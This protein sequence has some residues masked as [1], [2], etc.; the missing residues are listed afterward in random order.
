MKFKARRVPSEVD[1][2]AHDVE[3]GMTFRL[4]RETAEFEIRRYTELP[5]RM[6]TK[7]VHTVVK[8]DKPEEAPI[9]FDAPGSTEA[10]NSGGSEAAAV[11]GGIVT[12]TPALTPEASSDGRDSGLGG[13]ADELSTLSPQARP[14]ISSPPGSP[15]ISSEELNRALNISMLGAAAEAVNQRA[16]AVFAVDANSRTGL[17]GEALSL[18]AVRR[19]MDYLLGVAASRAEHNFADDSTHIGGAG[20]V[21]GLDMLG[22]DLALEQALQLQHNLAQ[23]LERRRRD[24]EV[25]RSLIDEMEAIEQAAQAALD[26]PPATVVLH[27][28]IEE[29]NMVQSNALVVM[30]EL[31]A[32]TSTD[33]DTEEVPNAEGEDEED[34]DGSLGPGSNWVPR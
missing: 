15:T 27:D 1:S 28:L 30:G 20:A 19:Q 17:E 3:Y 32:D 24:A 25:I 2:N 22:E 8:L 7:Q 10:N 26:N 21:P 23:E 29:M 12:S 16:D 33:P 14:G 18:Q 5:K 13:L 4:Q 11:G 9:L 6:I 31:E 34:A